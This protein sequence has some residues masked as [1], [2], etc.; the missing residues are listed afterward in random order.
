MTQLQ[1]ELDKAKR[2]YALQERAR[3]TDAIIGI[4]DERDLLIEEILD[5]DQLCFTAEQQ[6]DINELERVAEILGARYNAMYDLTAASE[7]MAEVNAQ[8][9]DHADLID[10]QECARF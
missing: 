5:G 9:E 8:M 1:Q 2:S 7:W 6:E 4:W 3:L 10:T